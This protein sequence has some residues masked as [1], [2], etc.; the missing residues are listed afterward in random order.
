A[1]LG[2]VSLGAGSAG[3]AL[4]LARAAQKVGTA[5]AGRF[6]SGVS[7]GAEAAGR[8]MAQGMRARTISGAS[9]VSNNAESS[10]SGYIEGN[11]R[12]PVQR[13][14]FR[15]IRRVATTQETIA[16]EHRDGVAILMQPGYDQEGNALY[17]LLEENHLLKNDGPISLFHNGNLNSKQISRY[18]NQHDPINGDRLRYFH[19]Y[20]RA[21]REDIEQ[22]E[23][24]FFW[25]TTTTQFDGPVAA[26][27]SVP[28]AQPYHPLA[29]LRDREL[30]G[31]NSDL[32]YE[33]IARI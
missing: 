13:F 16:F 28:E 32:T 20:P 26:F 17:T 1:V 10:T 8:D 24:A 18:F 30:G 23:G 5:V 27:K 4:S 22:V 31:R 11:L 33:L 6:A 19:A 2:W 7:G 9:A 12:L 25:N 14:L 15:Q 3:L 29:L 21:D